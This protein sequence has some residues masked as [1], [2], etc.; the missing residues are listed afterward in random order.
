MSTMRAAGRRGKLGADNK[1]RLRL[2]CQATSPQ[3]D[4]RRQQ[5]KKI[6]SQL[7]KPTAQALLKSWKAELRSRSGTADGKAPD[8]SG[9]YWPRPP[10]A[11]P[12]ALT[13][14]ARSFVRQNLTPIW[15]RRTSSGCSRRMERDRAALSHGG[16]PS[17][18]CLR[19]SRGTRPSSCFPR[20]QRYL[21]SFCC[22]PWPSTNRPTR[23]PT[24]L[25]S[26]RSVRLLGCTRIRAS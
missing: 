7:D 14:A 3:D 11:R 8:P 6:K 24:W 2:H 9:G 18:C 15:I 17:T 23:S 20:G 5:L 26:C 19:Q 22:S 1:R 12:D 13:R 10:C 4:E 25:C 21:P 16:W